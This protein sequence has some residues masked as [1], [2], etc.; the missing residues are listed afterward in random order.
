MDMDHATQANEIKRRLL[1][2][3][4]AAALLAV[5]KSWIYGRIHAK[6]LPFRYAK[7]GQYV[8]F[9]ESEILAFIDRQSVEPGQAA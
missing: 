7:V 9:D 5:Q 8:R 4:Q 2:V 1:T 6:T 3:D